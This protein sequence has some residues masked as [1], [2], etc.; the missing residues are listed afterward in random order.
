MICVRPNRESPKMEG[1]IGLA[2]DNNIPKEKEPAKPVQ[3]ETRI[4]R[5]E[6]ERQSVICETRR[7]DDIVKTDT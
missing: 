2:H 5:S 7:E 6:R 1:A 4:V 3:H